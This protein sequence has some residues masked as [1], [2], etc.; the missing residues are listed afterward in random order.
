MKRKFIAASI[1]G[2][3]FLFRTS[4]MI[5]VPAKSAAEIAEAL[6]QVNY[7]LNPGEAWA[8][9]ENSDNYA[10]DKCIKSYSKKRPIKIYKMY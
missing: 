1:K 2:N 9:H 8:V 10:I 4:T 6:T 5:L 7:K 3:E